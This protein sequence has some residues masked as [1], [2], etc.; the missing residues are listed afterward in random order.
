MGKIL[1]RN[2]IATITRAEKPLSMLGT[3]DYF[4]PTQHLGYHPEEF[5]VEAG[6]LLCMNFTQESS[7]G[8]TTLYDLSTGNHHGTITG[9]TWSTNSVWRES[10]EFNG[11]DNYI[12]LGSYENMQSA[13]LNIT[14]EAWVKINLIQTGGVITFI[15][16]SLIPTFSLSILVSGSTTY[17]S[18]EINNTTT[19][20][21][22]YDINDGNWHY[23]A[24]TYNGTAI[25]LYDQ[26]ERISSTN[27]H[28][29]INYNGDE[30]M[31]IGKTGTDIFG[32][33]IAGVRITRRYKPTLALHKYYH[34][35]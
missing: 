35:G 4:A 12:D 19:Y 32:G 22:T 30:N 9:A 27:L 34:G 7:D 29:A 21:D 20:S 11:V 13:A 33:N 8:G 18:F 16:T 6:T 31:Y 3:A 10:L 28:G 23:L 24:A 26:G 2:Q 25:A 17:P 15:D 14:L 1:T 5:S